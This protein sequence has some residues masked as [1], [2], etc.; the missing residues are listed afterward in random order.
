MMLDAIST[1]GRR[2]ATRPCN[3]SR[4]ETQPAS[5]RC[6]LAPAGLQEYQALIFIASRYWY[7]CRTSNNLSRGCVVASPARSHAFLLGPARLGAT[8]IFD[9]P[10]GRTSKTWSGGAVRLTPLFEEQPER[11]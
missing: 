7:G 2:C 5:L 1:T 3:L 9:G 4:E 6:A 11:A 10:A 8:S